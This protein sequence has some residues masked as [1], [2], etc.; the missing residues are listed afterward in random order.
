MYTGVIVIAVIARRPHRPRRSA[1]PGRGA[2]H[3]AI[4]LSALRK[5]KAVR[6]GVPPHWWRQ[7]RSGLQTMSWLAGTPEARH[8][9]LPLW[10]NVLRQG[11]SLGIYN[12]CIRW[13]RSSRQ[14]SWVERNAYFRYRRVVSLHSSRLRFLL[15]VEVALVVEAISMLY[16]DRRWIAGSWLGD[17]CITQP[18]ELAWRVR[19]RVL[20]W[21]CGKAVK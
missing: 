3:G 14:A 4:L 11:E 20:G 9:M 19:V 6:P 17:F 1:W 2:D 5:G 8:P 21:E 13:T 7:T 15:Q 10:Q 12:R 18:I 16:P